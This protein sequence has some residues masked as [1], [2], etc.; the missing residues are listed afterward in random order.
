MPYRPNLLFRTAF[1]HSRASYRLTAQIPPEDASLF[2]YRRGFTADV[3]LDWNLGTFGALGRAKVSAICAGAGTAS[4]DYVFKKGTIVVVPYQVVDF[5]L[6][7]TTLTAADWW[8]ATL[9]LREFRA[10]PAA[11]AAWDK[12]PS[13]TPFVTTLSQTFHS[14]TDDRLFFGEIDAEIINAR[15]LRHFRIEQEMAARRVAPWPSLYE[16]ELKPRAR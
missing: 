16:D 11:F 7:I 6:P 1:R 13:K 12:G 14:Y 5:P 10:I 15:Q 9:A 2:D 3:I 8:S 4:S